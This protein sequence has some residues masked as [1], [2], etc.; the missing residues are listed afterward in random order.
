MNKV[1]KNENFDY[2]L[3]RKRPAVPLVRYD[4]GEV[5]L[6]S[7]H[8]FMYE[9]TNMIINDVNDNHDVMLIA[10]KDLTLV[11]KNYGLRLVCTAKANEGKVLKNYGLRPV[12]AARANEGEECPF[13]G[14]YFRLPD[15]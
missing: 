7:L 5:P 2:E 14:P 10:K 9:E 15:G 12:F 13:T 4:N 6:P 1:V 3:E 11:L 8:E